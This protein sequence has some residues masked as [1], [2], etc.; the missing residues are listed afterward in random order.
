MKV[1]CIADE[2]TVRGFRL[3][4]VAG[5]A[6][7]AAPEATA[8]VEAA[9]RTD[10]GVLILTEKIADSVRP[11]VDQIRFER[12]RPLIVEIPGREGV[13]PGRKDLRQLVQEAVGIRLEPEKG[14]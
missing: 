10:C 14:T 12:E 1:H 11:L 9:A 6:V 7:A 2:D 4:G 5:V 13:L 8:A 3:A